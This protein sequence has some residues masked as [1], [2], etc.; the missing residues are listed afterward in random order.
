[1]LET[2]G[3]LIPVLP[4]AAL[5]PWSRRRSQILNFLHRG[6]VFFTTL[7]Y[8]TN[9]GDISPLDS[10]F[11]PQRVSLKDLNE[12]F[13]QLPT[14]PVGNPE[15]TKRIGVEA[16]MLPRLLLYPQGDSALQPPGPATDPGSNSVSW[17]VEDVFLTD[18]PQAAHTL[19]DSFRTDIPR[20]SYVEQLLRSNAPP[21]SPKKSP[22][23]E[24]EYGAVFEEPLLDLDCINLGEQLTASWQDESASEPLSKTLPTLGLTGL[25]DGLTGETKWNSNTGGPL[26]NKTTWI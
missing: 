24:E 16:V 19:P 10:Y 18:A 14:N 6:P 2:P 4:G 15:E 11:N 17:P 21:H 9:V 13:A 20:P 5:I 12:R 8:D 25:M 22:P 1:M 3:D 7:V 26:L 23:E